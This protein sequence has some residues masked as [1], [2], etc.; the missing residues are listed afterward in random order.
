MLGLKWLR[1]LD[2][3]RLKVLLGA[4]FLALAVPAAVLIAQAYGQ[5][6]WEAFRRNQLLAED[7]AAQVDS[8]LRAAVATEEARSFGDYSFLVVAGKDAAANF[9]QRSPLSA[10]PVEG[11]V[12][13]TLGYFQVDALGN[14]TTPLLPGP[15]VD[16]ATYG[17]SADEQSAR[18][19]L[20][21]S[22]S[23]V[24]AANR[25]VLRSPD[26]P[27]TGGA[28]S[29]VPA[30]EA[31]APG[32]LPALA[33]APT[34]RASPERAPATPTPRA[35]SAR[36][37][38]APSAS[39][40][41]A[42]AA[43]SESAPPPTPPSSASLSAPSAAF[44]PS[45]ELTR[46][47]A[48][49]LK[50]QMEKAEE[51]QAAFDRLAPNA[52]PAAQNTADEARPQ[53]ELDV[54]AASQAAASQAAAPQPAAPQAAAKQLAKSDSRKDAESNVV[55]AAAPGANAPSEPRAQVAERRKRS[56]QSLVPEAKPADRESDADKT[57]ADNKTA[58][59]VFRVQ[60]FESE[61]DPLEVGVLD[62]GEIVMFR[63]VWRGGQRYIQGALI[64]RAR[65]VDLAVGSPYRSS[66]LA[67]MSDVAV[68]YRGR[69]LATLHAAT[70][71][72]SYE[73]RP[74]A[75]LAGTPLHR[76]RLSPPF[77]DLELAFSVNQL[78][79]APGALL[80]LWI[81]VT[82]AAVLCG[83]FYFM[84][85]LAVGQ[86]RL[87]RQQQD[88]VSAVSHELKTPLT[89]IRMYGE[90]LKAGWADDAKKQTY[91]DYIHSESERLSRLIENVLQ[92]AR[93]TRS[94][95]QLDVKRVA[96][97]E[98]LDMVRSKCATQAERSGFT[99]TIRDGV[100]AGTELALDADAFAQVLINLVDNALKFSSGAD[101][102]E[103]EIASRLETDGW[104]LFTV[105]DF[106]PGIPKGQLKKIF[107][108]FYR[109]PDELTRATAGTGIGLALV[110]QLTAAMG[111]RV[112]VRNCE[113]GAEFRVSFPAEVAAS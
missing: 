93:L 37:S 97:A 94:S 49:K 92:L 7:L 39:A 54:D 12:P 35:S 99:L 46:G 22:L 78:P 82:L 48:Q 87:A 19:T 4:F 31:P 60:T 71:G 91:Y 17:I 34:Q 21:A 51:T 69:P 58:R 70:G 24:L 105:R 67:S 38:A 96:S 113:P 106:G 13:G 42:P 43:A 101:R 112:E 109:P 32:S 64:D 68:T 20:F 9:V 100:P 102:K 50:A 6:K 79:S 5:L 103:I 56:E 52:A 27:G 11:A 63:N 15:G 86:M 74:V 40:S 45:L 41:S 44:A 83:G 66:S 62:T 90:M 36:A 84:Y 73:S 29:P 72:V 26:A 108:L 110:L 107:E 57:A 53:K 55:A 30:S 85:R 65:F 98:L 59:T 111:G 8:G 81:S 10:F 1:K 61:L 95:Q 75:G 14:L 28:V 47:A 2:E 25:L 80:L 104:V 18:R 77:G 3:R 33:P 89:S 23:E 16:A 88:F 76:A